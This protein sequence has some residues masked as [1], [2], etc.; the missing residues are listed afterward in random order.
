MCSRGCAWILWCT[1]EHLVSICWV[2]L[3]TKQTINLQKQKRK[4]GSLTYAVVQNK[5]LFEHSSNTNRLIVPKTDS[6]RSQVG[7]I[8]SYESSLPH[9]DTIGR[10]CLNFLRDT[11]GQSPKLLTN[12]MS[13]KRTCKTNSDSN[14]T[15]DDDLAVRLVNVKLVQ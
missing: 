14:Q 8:M 5:V 11:K 7:K 10:G 9:Q 13:G 3:Q 6:I 2:H 12:S 15:N 1:C 4:F